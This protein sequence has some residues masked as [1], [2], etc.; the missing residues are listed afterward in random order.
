MR[1]IVSQGISI[2]MAML[3]AAVIWVVATSEQ[4]PS[5]EA[6][7]QDTLPLELLHRAEGLV[8]YQRTAETVRVKVRAPQANWDQLRPAS[9]RVSADLKGLGTGL[10]QIPII[11]QVTDP[12]V[13]V[14]AIEPTQVGVRL[15]SLKSR[16]VEVHADVLDAPPIGYTYRPPVVEPLTVTVSGPAVLVDQVVEGVVDIFLRGSKAPLERDSVVSLRDAQ[17]KAVTGLTIVPTSVNVKVQ[18][19]QRVGY[20]DV[21]IKTVL[22]GNVA[23]GY[24]VSNI[25]VT[26]STA[27][28]VGNAE[29]MAK[30]QGFVETLPI[31]VEGATAD[32]TKRAVL[33][34]PEGVSV[35]NSDGIN[36][37]V[38]VTPIIGGQTV[39]R[40]ATLQGLRLGLNA[41][42]SPDM[43]EVILSGP[44]TTL[45]NL[46]PND[47]QVVLDVAGLAPGT[48]SI[49]PRVPTLPNVLRVQSIVPEAIQVVITDPATPT[50]SPTLALPTVSPT[51]T[52]T[53]PLTSVPTIT[54]T[55]LVTNTTPVATP[56]P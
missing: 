29:V 10:H 53:R 32:V 52:G 9:F 11:V 42:I 47:I 25:V 48:H 37:Q 1:S 21:S 38:A 4:N 50:I 24:W 6:Y 46:T 15:E 12:R 33:A 23:S 56:K 7:F 41:A 3:I 22:K 27:T 20:K 19:E 17:G 43:V 39:R 54:V 8:V 49:K 34:L 18:V 36:V 55:P 35:L 16:E 51:I 5:R 2:V 26:P 40:R 14:L 44:V 13:T 28:I 30:I 31:E 45:N